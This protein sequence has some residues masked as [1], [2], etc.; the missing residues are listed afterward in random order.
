MATLI[1]LQVRN[2]E[3]TSLFVYEDAIGKPV[4]RIF[5]IKNLSSSDVRGGHKNKVAY[6]GIICIEGTATVKVVKDDKEELFYL[7][8]PDKCLMIEPNEWHEIF[9]FKDNSILLA[10]SDMVFNPSHYSKER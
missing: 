6:E 10:F 5:F 4:N 1:T 8:Q 2:K 9:D 7:D 3:G